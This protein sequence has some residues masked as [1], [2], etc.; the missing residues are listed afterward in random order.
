MTGRDLIMYILSNGLEN[1]PI[2]ENGK[3]LGFM[4]EM[5]A[6]IKFDQASF[7]WFL[8]L[9]ECSLVTTLCFAS[10]LQQSGSVYTYMCSFPYSPLRFIAGF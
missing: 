7:V 3:I 5:E 8:M 2:Y 9:L 10:A 4:N 1:E 6:A